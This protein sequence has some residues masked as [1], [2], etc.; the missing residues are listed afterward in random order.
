MMQASVRPKKNSLFPCVIHPIR[1]VV[2][3]TV[4]STVHA[5]KSIGVSRGNGKPNKEN[6]V[7]EGAYNLQSLIQI[8]EHM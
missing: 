7:E 6:I 3:T 1:H 8:I 4:L 5:I 2:V